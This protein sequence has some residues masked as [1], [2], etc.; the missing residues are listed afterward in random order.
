M[1]KILLLSIAVALSLVARVSADEATMR[2]GDSFDLRISGVPPDDQTTISSNYTIDGQGYF[3][4]SYLGKIKVSGMTQSE[5]QTLVERSYMNK[6]I[7][8]HPTVTLTVA[9]VTRF[10]NVGGQVKNPGRIPYTADMTLLSAI[11]AAA[12]FTDYA[13]QGKVHLL[14]GSHVDIINVKKIRANPSLDV[15]VLPGDMI[16]VPESPW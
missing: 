7:F 13:D 5:I 9:N 8:T 15:K 3:N 1:K 6:G 16:Q 12:D 4:I 10:V 2:P 11:N 14:R